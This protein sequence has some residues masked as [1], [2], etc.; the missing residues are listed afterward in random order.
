MYKF[1]GD[2]CSVAAHGEHGEKTWLGRLVDT[3]F[4]CASDDARFWCPFVLRIVFDHRRTS[5][6]VWMEGT[7]V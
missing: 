2:F 6:V 1:E 7:G 4:Q 5:I 3:I